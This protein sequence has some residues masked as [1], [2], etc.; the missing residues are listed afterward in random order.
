MY[1]DIKKY[2]QN[3][4]KHANDGYTETLEWVKLLFDQNKKVCYFYLYEYKSYIN[5]F[6]EGLSDSVNVVEQIHKHNSKPSLYIFVN[7]L[8]SGISNILIISICK[9]TIQ[10]YIGNN[11]FWHLNK[12]LNFCMY[13]IQITTHT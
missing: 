1:G 6:K 3:Y 8:D 7:T 9:Y 5:M 11:E 4:T 13:H 10:A 2:R 12:K